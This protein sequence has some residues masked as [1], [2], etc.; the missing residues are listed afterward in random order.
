[1]SPHDSRHLVERYWAAMQENDWRKA[2]ELFDDGFV[3]DWPQ[4]GERIR[5]RD[6]FVAVNAAYPAAGRWQFTVERLVAG[7]GSATT[8]VRVTDGVRQ[9][10]VVTFFE[11]GGGRIQRLTEY[12]PDPFEAAPW[13]ARWVERR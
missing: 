11:L 9:D 13:R 4:S 5:S 7:E 12:W 10:R 3:L 2:S 8:D 1:M 6:D